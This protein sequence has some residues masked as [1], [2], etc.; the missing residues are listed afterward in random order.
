MIKKAGNQKNNPFGNPAFQYCF[1]SE[2]YYWVLM[3][4]P[5][6]ALQL[7]A[8]PVLR[9]VLRSVGVV[10]TLK[11]E[12]GRPILVDGLPFRGSQLK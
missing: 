3:V 6:F 8:T 7:V 10:Y 2:N 1:H 9:L 5:A 11:R 4:L 12:G